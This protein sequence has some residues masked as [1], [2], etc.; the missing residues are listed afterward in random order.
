MAAND[1]SRR[2]YLDHAATGW[3]KRP[4][5]SGAMKSYIDDVGAAAGRGV[6]ATALDAA[7]IVHGLRRK[8]SEAISA[9]SNECI[10]FHC[11]G[12][13]ALNAAIFGL[14]RP[15]DH[16]V[17]TAAEHNSVLRPLDHLRSEQG[18]DVDVA[19]LDTHAHVCVE[20][21]LAKVRPDTTVVAITGASNVTGGVSPIKQV[22]DAL[23]GHSAILMCDAAQNFGW[24]PIDVRDGIDVL[25]A[26]GHKAG[27]GPLGTGFLYVAPEHH[28]R[29][30]PTIFGG[31]GSQSES[32]RMP[33]NM[34]DKLESG[35][36]N[37]PAI[38]GWS[39]GFPDPATIRSNA[40]R[41]A[42]LSKRLHSEIESVSCQKTVV[43]EIPIVSFWSD[44]IDAAEI[45][46][47]LSSEFGIEVRAGHH[48]S[49]LVVDALGGPSSGVVRASAGP[50][51]TADDIRALGTAL[52][53]N[54]RLRDRLKTASVIA[55]S[56]TTT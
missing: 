27:G 41:A 49:A 3:P 10:S 5:V 8:L 55:P 31:T 29:L 23:A 19:A 16:V 48:C 24:M 44:S 56:L 11:S 43:G 50:E 36:L 52:R 30:R 22:A 42:E 47:I 9:P 12:T 26:P 1:S 4:Q 28:G 14:I 35:N 34:P 54:F 46:I 2:I 13:A 17:T 18:V 53:R 6:Y 25:A 38:A 37:V 20:S 21:V 33:D 32:L 7:N 51:T 15:G 40:D 45:A 39:A